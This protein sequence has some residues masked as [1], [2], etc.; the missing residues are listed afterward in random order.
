MTLHIYHPK[1]VVWSN[2]EPRM[3]LDCVN[4]GKCESCLYNGDCAGMSVL[5]LDA[6]CLSSSSGDIIVR[7][8]GEAWEALQEA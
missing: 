6:S 5:P 7:W 4:Q 2:G 1:E 3:S 8:R